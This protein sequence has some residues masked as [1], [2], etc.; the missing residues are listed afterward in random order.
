MQSR[1]YQHVGPLLSSP[2]CK[3]PSHYYFFSGNLRPA[4]WKKAEL[5]C[6]YMNQ[7]KA[8]TVSPLVQIVSL[9][10]LLLYFPIVCIFVPGLPVHVSLQPQ[11]CCS[12]KQYPVVVG[13]QGKAKRRGNVCFTVD[14][15]WRV[16]HAQKWQL[17]AFI[18]HKSVEDFKKK[19]LRIN[20]ISKENCLKE[21]NVLLAKVLNF[22]LWCQFL[23]IMVEVLLSWAAA[24]PRRP[25]VLHGVLKYWRSEK[26]SE[27]IWLHSPK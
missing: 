18:T 27:K 10:C 13:E 21:Q 17:G 3:V 23:R 4:A 19:S 25:T 9:S 22:G 1:I 26:M 20:K 5:E 24:L 12:T 6:L 8:N 16:C 11:P 14:F 2:L 7:A 15:A